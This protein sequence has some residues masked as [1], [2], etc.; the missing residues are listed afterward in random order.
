MRNIAWLGKIS[1]FW[2]A[3]LYFYYSRPKVKKTPPSVEELIQQQVKST[4]TNNNQ[5][6]ESTSNFPANETI[7]LDSSSKHSSLNSYELINSDR[8]KNN[9]LHIT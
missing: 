9:K 3:Y 1:F 6:S 8:D 7:V 2:Y 4:T 5:L